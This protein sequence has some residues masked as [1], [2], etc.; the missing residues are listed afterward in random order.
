MA[1]GGGGGTGGAGGSS[2]MNPGGPGVSAGA[3]G[4]PTEEDELTI[5]RAAMNK[6]LKEL[7]PNVRIANESRELVLNCCSEF[8]HYI[9]TQANEICNQHHKKTINAE[10]ILTALEKLGFKEYC[11]D[12]QRVFAD[13]K[14]VAAKRRK[15]SSRLEHLGVP[16]EELLRQQQEL[17]A[18]ARQEQA[19]QQQQDWASIQQAAVT[20]LPIAPDSDEDEY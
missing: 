9:A 12:A 18:K 14:E 20:G 2:G 13:C 15:Q 1:G 19:E 8:I 11:D 3:V 5:P 16:E 17:F 6:M 7:L 10:H 4:A